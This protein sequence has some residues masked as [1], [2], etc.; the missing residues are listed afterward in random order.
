MDAPAV[1]LDAAGREEQRRP[2]FQRARE[3]VQVRVLDEVLE[4]VDGAPALYTYED[5]TTD[6]EGN[7]QTNY[8]RY[9]VALAEAPECAAFVPE[10][11]RALLRR[12][13]CCSR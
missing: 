9:T 8:Y 11:S 3:V 12:C 4:V 10:L 7:R 6:S 5:E 13:C 2:G 1:Q